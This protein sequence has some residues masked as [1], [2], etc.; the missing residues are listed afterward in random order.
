MHR[1][2][3]ISGTVAARLEQV[4]KVVAIAIVVVLV[5]TVFFQV[6]RRTLTGRSFVEIEEL[7]I[8]LAAWVAFT[9]VSYAARRKVH[10]RIEVFVEKLPFAARNTIEFLINLAIFAVCILLTYYGYRLAMRKVMV[11]MTV[12]PIHQGYWYCAFPVGMAL[13]SLFM[14]DNTIQTL[15]RYLTREPYPLSDPLAEVP[16]A[17]ATLTEGGE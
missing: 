2:A 14:L 13:T 10:V 1:L 5:C 12:L 4:V 17:A 3:A 15:N 16:M 7:S 8:V 11:P 9:T 6:A